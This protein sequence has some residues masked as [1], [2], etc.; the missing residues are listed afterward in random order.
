MNF[1]KLNRQGHKVATP[2]T[3]KEE[4]FAI[5]NTLS[6]RENLMKA[7]QGD[8]DAKKRLVQ[9]NYNDLL[10]DGR[11]AGCCHPSSFFAG[12]VDCNGLAESKEIAQR[13]LAHKDEIQLM[14]LSRS[15]RFGLHYVCRRQMGRTILENQVRVAQITNGHFGSRPATSD[16]YRH[17]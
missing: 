10:P 8:E 1:I 6:N 2:V 17:R 9:F 5:R 3:S 16:V 13:F 11:L 15:A 12:D 14:E 4:Y 7:H